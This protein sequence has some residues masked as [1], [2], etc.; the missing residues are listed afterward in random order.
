MRQPFFLGMDYYPEQWPKEQ[1][2]EDLKL[3]KEANVT[4]VRIAEF[5]WSL[6]EPE[7]GRFEF[8]WLDEIMEKIN[9]YAIKVILGTPT[10]APPLWLSLNHPD[11]LQ[12]DDKGLL[13]GTG[14]RRHYCVNSDAYQRYCDRIVTI[15]AERYGEHPGV[16]GWQIDNEAGCHNA[17]RC[18][19]SSCEQKFREWLKEK[20]NTVERLNEAWGNVFWSGMVT[21]WDQIVLHKNPVYHLNPSYTLDFQRFSSDSWIYFLNRQAEIIRTRSS[22]QFI[23]H[24][25]TNYAEELDGFKLF[26][27]MDCASVDIY[28]QPNRTDPYL[29]SMMNDFVY[30]WKKKRHWVLELASGTSCTPFYKA[31][32]PRKGEIRMWAYQAYLHG[33]EGV[34]YFRWRK[35]RYGIEMLGNGLLDHDSKPRRF[36]HDVKELGTKLDW[37]SEMLAGSN[38]QTGVAIV[39]DYDDYFISLL[40]KFQIG[41]DYFD[42][43]FKYYKA[44]RR[45]GINVVFE[46]PDADFSQYKMIITPNQY[47][48]TRETA[49]HYKTYVQEGGMIVGVQRMGMK[50]KTN[51]MSCETLPGMLTELF[52][53]EIEEY[54]SRGKEDPARIRLSDELGGQCMEVPDWSFILKSNGAHALGV[55]E[56]YNEG[57]PAVTSHG[58]GKGTALFIG[59]VLEESNVLDLMKWAVH[60]AGVPYINGIPDGVE[61]IPFDS[62]LAVLNLTPERKE[63]NRSNGTLMMEPYGIQCISE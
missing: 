1:W 18:Y 38:R 62:M 41:V 33:A 11:T 12:V 42:H 45:L 5:T 60:Q 32:L 54:E 16:I 30:S 20:Y 51:T 63:W 39:V 27:K 47:S 56:T 57:Q 4:V 8:E 3:M 2:D 43:I 53:V 19:C 34:V 23:T 10:E 25:M 55:Y 59:A 40:Q 26:D 58:Y 7:D 49:D 21:D 14:T 24:N 37:L 48:M 9:S 36:Y 44:L 31:I 46:K 6:M 17:V 22:E 35:S 13:R 15:L 50:S 29:I 52:G 61:V 28:P